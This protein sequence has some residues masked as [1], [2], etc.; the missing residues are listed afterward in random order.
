MSLTS[1]GKLRMVSYNK[2]VSTLAFFEDEYLGSTEQNLGREGLPRAHPPVYMVSPSIVQKYNAESGHN[3][4]KSKERCDERRIVED[5]IQVHGITYH[6]IV[7]VD[8][9]TL[10]N[11][12]PRSIDAKNKN[13]HANLCSCPSLSSS[14]SE[15][16]EVA[17]GGRLL[18]PLDRSD[19]KSSKAALGS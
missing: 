8:A 1:A 12:L 16:R 17:Q 19:V 15:K 3:E 14:D 7:L 5:N 18:A 11:T 10:K 2:N 9:F 13:R 6:V 4:V